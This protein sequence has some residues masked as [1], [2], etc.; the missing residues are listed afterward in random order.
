VALKLSYCTL[1]WKNPDLEPALEELKKAGWEGWEGRV[2]LDW[3]GPP[4]RVRRICKDT[5]MPMVVYTASGSPDQ[6]EWEHVERNKRRM[7]YAAAIEVDCFMFMSGPKPKDRPVGEDDMKAAAEGAEA[8]AEYAAQYGLEVSYHIHTNTLI[9]SIEHW[10]RYTSLLDRAKLCI[11][12]S[13]AALWGYDPV[14]SI[15]DFR[16]QLNYIHLQDYS[17]TSRDENGRYQSVWCDVGETASV[18]FPAILNTLEKIGFERW[19]TACPGRVIPG[20]EDPCRQ[21]Q[22]SRRM[23]EY[24]KGLGY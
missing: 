7:E 16:E 12:V 5:G 19:V 24:L 18:D 3:L 9:D 15:L 8:W 17:S 4:Q 11:D 20:Q 22:H 23:R 1:Y 6:R 2:P 10:R 14:Q 21:A 13:H